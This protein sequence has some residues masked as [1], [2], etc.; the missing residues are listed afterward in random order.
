M[1]HYISISTEFSDTG[2]QFRSKLPIV[3]PEYCLE[4]QDQTTATPQHNYSQ[5]HEML[6]TFKHSLH[7]WLATT[8][9]TCKAP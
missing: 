6:T 7:A 8:V 4:L 2:R 1:K 9:P 3:S 5:S